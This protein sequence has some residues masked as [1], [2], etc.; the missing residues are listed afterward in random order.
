MNTCPVFRR[1]GGYSYGY[2]VPGPIGSLLAPQRDPQKFAS[3]NGV[4]TAEDVSRIKQASSAQEANKR[5]QDILLSKGVITKEQYDQVMSQEGPAAVPSAP[6]PVVPVAQPAVTQP[7]PNFLDASLS[8]QGPPNP[9]E[10]GAPS[11]VDREPV[12]EVNSALVPIRVFPVGGLERGKMTPAF[13]TGGVGLTPYGFIKATMVE[14]SSSPN[15]DD[16]PLPGFIPTPARTAIRSFTSRP[17]APVLAP[18]SSG[19]TRIRSGRSP[20]RLKGIS[21]ATSTAPI[22]AICP[23]SA[24]AIH[25]CG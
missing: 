12:T 21:K 8:V 5:L 15:G 19:M 3:L 18:T 7:R 14:D 13:K 16:F 22:I 9:T 4:L 25:R 6:S 20:E 10:P 1:S 23:P 2:T 17:A 11:T 24:L